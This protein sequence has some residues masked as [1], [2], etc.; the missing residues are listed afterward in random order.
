MISADAIRDGLVQG[1][2]LDTSGRG[3]A[4]GGDF[5]GAGVLLFA[6]DFGRA[7][8]VAPFHRGRIDYLIEKSS[9]MTASAWAG[10]G[11]DWDQPETR[12]EV[13]SSAMHHPV[14]G[15]T[16]SLALLAGIVLLQLP[17][18]LSAQQRSEG[19]VA[20]MFA[21]DQK[22]DPALA[23]SFVPADLPATGSIKSP[24]RIYLSAGDL[25]RTFDVRR[26]FRPDAIIVPTNTEL[27]T[28][29]SSPATQRVL[30]SRVQKQPEIMRDLDEQIAERRKQEPPASGAEKGVL[31][32]GIDSFFARLPRGAR[33]DNKDL[34]L[35]KSACFVATDFAAG[36]AVD[37]RELFAQDR[38]RKGIA[39]CLKAT[40]V[41]GARSLVLPL[42]GAA[43]SNTQANDAQYEGQRVL[44]ECRL[45]NS[46][47][48]I[49][50]G[51][52]D[53]AAAR[54][55]LREIG[56]VQWDREIAD[57]FKVDSSSR[58][59]QAALTAYRAYAEQIR[60]A[61]R[62]GLAGEKTVANDVN[63]TCAAILNVR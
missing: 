63:G 37:R 32:I 25:E 44:K 9:M 28:T 47:A 16:R 30:I 54:R 24:L 6:T 35:P 18:L 27:L 36:G 12:A 58:A 52:H 46:T 3:P 34:P 8:Q 21:D 23:M 29:A 40:D 49:A 51:I 61:F 55:N 10:G 22:R 41:A 62:K 38:M 56:L 26:E 20:A 43:S 17:G 5:D 19:P 53:F 2:L 11:S 31:Q 48:G 42:M 1:D 59:A 33:D 39:A 45:I 57:M 50:L 7:I 60:Q 4:S 13:E 14:T 15:R